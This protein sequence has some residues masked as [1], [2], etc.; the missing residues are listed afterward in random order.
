[1]KPCHLT[2]NLREYKGQR[3]IDVTGYAPTGAVS[4][5]PAGK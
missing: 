2:V 1:M 5:P 4:L 3:F